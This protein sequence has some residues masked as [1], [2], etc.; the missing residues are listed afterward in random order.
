MLKLNRILLF[1]LLL[2]NISLFSQTKIRGVILDDETQ[3]PLS[4][5]KISL[6]GLN[7]RYIS[8][9]KGIFFIETNSV[10]KTLIISK[11]GYQTDSV[12]I[13]QNKYQD[14]IIYLK[15]DNTDIE[16]INTK[17]EKNKAVDYIKELIK[18]KKNNSSN[19]LK[20]YNYEQYTKLETDINNVDSKLKSYP[21]LKDF[22]FVF[23]NA[24]TS[25]ATGKIYAPIFMSETISDFYYQNF[26]RRRKEIIKSM[27]MAGIEN[28]S[29]GKFAGQMYFDIN[30][31]KSYVK[32]IDKEFIS[33]ISIYGLLAYN[34]EMTDSAFIDNSWCYQIS[35]S[36]KRKYEYTFNGNI[37]VADTA[38][39]LKSVFA[40]MSETANLGIVSDFYI[41]TDFQKIENNFYFPY[42]EELF[43]DFNV[44]DFSSGIFA[45]KYVE[46]KNIYLNT[47]YKP[48]FF[49]PTEFRDIEIHNDAAK[50]DSYYWIKNRPVSITKK[51]KEIYSTVDSV[52]QQNTFKTIENLIYFSATGFLKTHVLDFGPIYKIYSKNA[53]EGNRFRLGFRT[54]NKFSKKIEFNAYTAYGFSDNDAKYGIET[55]LKFDREPWTTAQINYTDDF[56]QLSSHLG[57]FG[58][59]NI[60]SVSGKNDKLLKAKTL[61]AIIERDLLKSLTGI[62]KYSRQTILPNEI[63]YFQNTENIIV[64]EINSTKLTLNAH[65]GINEEYIEFVF[66][67]HSFGSLYPILEFEYSYA[68][69]EFLN[70]EYKFSELK[71]GIHHSFSLGFL[72][73]TKYLVEFGKIYG[74]VP[75]PLLKLHEGSAGISYSLKT[76]NLMDYYEFASD[77]YL[78]FFAEHHF[79]GLFFN[80]IPFLRKLKLREIIFAK[81]VWGDISEKNRNILVFPQTLSDVKKP[82]LE[83][84]AGIENIFNILSINYI[85]RITHLQNPNVRKQGILIGFQISL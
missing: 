19:Y 47:N 85:K 54:G 36:P 23:E 6:K 72:G 74:T 34:Y 82:Y 1:L 3:F 56:L 78:S 20:T 15:T 44:S 69:S 21:V 2:S 84:G 26:P 57:T 75:Y 39:A 33:P 38:F 67:R 70:S 10:L 14:F 32:I 11:K 60:F 66:N 25:A 18:N 29:I 27:K 5:A 55:K 48:L 51:E 12:N 62:I 65:F 52:K 37:W 79:K 53:I 7:T 28:E 63:L 58:Y 41:K 71:I 81:G 59:D 4:S 40:T 68:I 61:E 43:F 13:E 80:K 83:L 42:K 77:R 35:F 46:R 8:D 76:F 24:D 17:S 73:K 31:Y 49:S 30:F 45:K 64:P 9:E 16:K 22:K 50:K